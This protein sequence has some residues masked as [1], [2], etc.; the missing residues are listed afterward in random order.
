VRQIEM[1]YFDVLPPAVRE[2]IRQYGLS[3]MRDVFNLLADGTLTIES[4]VQRIRAQA[5]AL[6]MAREADEP[7]RPR[8]KLR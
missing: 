6:G 7:V 8:R 1:H 3:G 2:E 5:T 4:F